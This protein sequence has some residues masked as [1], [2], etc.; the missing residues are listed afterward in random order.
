MLVLMFHLSYWGWRDPAS[1]TGVALD[2]AAHF[3]TLGPWF[4]GGWVGV[5]IFFVISGFVIAY[6]ANAKSADAFLISRL[7]RLY[8]A[9]W[10][11]ATVTFCLV[12]AVELIPVDQAVRSYLRS[13]ALWPRGPWID[14]VYWSL[15]VELS[16]YALVMTLL[17]L[18]RFRN[19]EPVMEVVGTV[20]TV[21]CIVALTAT[22]GHQWPLFSWYGEIL[23]LGHGHSFAL[24]VTFWLTT[25]SAMTPRRMRFCLVYCAGIAVV[26][27]TR[28][29][30]LMASL[31]F[32]A[33]LGAFYLSTQYN[34]LAVRYLG[35][36]GV[37]LARIAGLMTYPLYLLHDIAGAIMIRW[38]VRY[39]NLPD[40]LALAAA[41]IGLLAL[42][43][44]VAMVAEPRIRP[45]IRGV[46]KRLLGFCAPAL[47]RRFERAT[48]PAV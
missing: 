42:S 19:I 45:V 13:V 25:Q 29:G 8:P 10:V 9:A 3:P 27:L 33:S 24:G 15:R 21:F 31:L 30:K 22:G 40:T 37:R 23:L 2:G 11:C 41:I 7:A 48:V 46:S 12:W 6:T 17:V 26:L 5:Q 39:A 43:F 36:G 14:Q 1:D 16:F 18:D 34:A 28:E 4:S 32:A 38:L 20:S 44:A 35:A 47:R